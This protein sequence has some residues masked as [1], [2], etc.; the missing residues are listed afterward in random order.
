MNVP[1]APLTDEQVQ[2]IYRRIA[3]KEPGFEHGDFLTEFAR[4]LLRAD[5]ENFAVLR[6]AAV[7]L[8]EKYALAT[9]GKTA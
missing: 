2:A 1:Q 5:F 6:P 3:L 7:E 9:E 8:I 4:A